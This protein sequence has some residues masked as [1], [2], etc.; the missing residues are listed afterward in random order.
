MKQYLVDTNIFIDFLRGDKNPEKAKIAERFLVNN[1]D[2]IKISVITVTE[3]YAGYKGK[4]E[5]RQIKDLLDIYSIMDINIDVSVKAGY[6]KN[7]YG[8]SHNVCIGDCL[9]AAT[10]ILNDLTL[11]TANFKHFPMVDDKINGR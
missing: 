8:P 3:L 10:A 9:I 6:L 5:E 4:K 2:N 1:I 7:K 11:V